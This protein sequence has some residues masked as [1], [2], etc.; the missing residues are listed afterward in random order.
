MGGKLIA[1]AKGKEK[2]AYF[3]SHV[4]RNVKKD[5]KVLFPIRG[6]DKLVTVM[7]SRLQWSTAMNND[8]VIL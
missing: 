1:E 2:D 7:A 5:S 8:P 6:K 3:S 4:G